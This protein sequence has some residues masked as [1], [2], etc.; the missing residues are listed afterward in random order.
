M[1]TP[2]FDA[3]AF[4]AQTP[5]APEIHPQEAAPRHTARST[6][7][8]SEAMVQTLERI[9]GSGLK[10]EGFPHHVLGQLLHSPEL[11]GPFLE[12]W[13][14]GKLGLAFSVREQE[15]VILRMACL[16]ASNYVWKHHVKVG[17]EF[18]ITD[19]ELQGIKRGIY[20]LFSQREQ[21][22]LQ[23]TDEMVNKRT[24]SANSWQQWGDQLSP[25]E[26]VDLIAL[27]SQY[28][29]FALTNNVLQVPLEPALV[30][31]PSLEG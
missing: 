10:G 3:P 23:L 13:V 1:V 14:S 20:D 6:Q 26:A 22:I 9:P 4:D 29:L 30:S 8:L 16:Y 24:V 5:G 19:D 27:I 7:E 11:L 28:V 15:L 21:A 12:W 31:Q 18:G 25:R 2:A 17:R